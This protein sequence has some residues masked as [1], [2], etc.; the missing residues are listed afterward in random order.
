MEDIGDAGV[1]FSR[2]GKKTTVPADIVLLSIGR[3]PNLEGMGFRE[4]GLDMDKNGIRTDDRMRTNLPG[5]YA[6]GDVTGR[7]LL[8]HSASRM[9]E[10][11][12]ADILGRKDRWRGHAVPWVVFTS[13]ET[14]GCGLTEAEA[15][16]KGVDVKTVTVPMRLSGRYL[17]EHPKE[18]GVCK[19]V[20]DK[21]TD[22]VLG[23]TLLGSGC[24]EMIFG[25]ALMIEAELRTRDIREM[26]FPHPTV[27]E[28]LRE[29]LF[30]ME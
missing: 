30:A 14:A 28:V 22:V 24:S 1:T 7:S 11:A 27:S 19:I 29:A 9:G 16:A 13:P 21:K 6:V 2:D 20:A 26:I 15:R 25:A 10:I 5:V 12:V 4:A 8:A 17:A 18:N 3:R 23:V